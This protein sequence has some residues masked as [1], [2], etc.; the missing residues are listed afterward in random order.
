[1]HSMV[2]SA[3]KDASV[4]I[5]SQIKNGNYLSILYFFDLADP[6]VS[7]SRREMHG[8]SQSGLDKIAKCV[9]DCGASQ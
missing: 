8:E 6:V 9:L 2:L 7:G 3:T 4:V 1:M 5:Y